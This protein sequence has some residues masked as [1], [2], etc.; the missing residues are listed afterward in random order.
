[1]IGEVLGP[2]RV[3]SKVGEGGMGE[4]YRARDTKLNRDVAIKVLPPALSEDP[5]PSTGSGSPRATS[6]GERVSRLRR[7]AQILATLNHPNIAAI[8]GLEEGAPS[9]GPGQAATIALA[10]EY[11]EGETLEERLRRGAIP[12]DEATAIA[13]QIAEALEAAHEKGI[14]HRDLKP[15]NVKLTPDGKVKVLDFG[16]AKALEGE[17]ADGAGGQL[18]HSPTMS[19]HATEAGLILGTAAY[20]SPEQARGKPVDKRADIWA[21]GVVLF[22][23]LSGARLFTGDTVSDILAAVLTRE[24]DWTALPAAT[25]PALVRLLRRCLERDPKKRLHDIADARFDLDDA[26]LTGGEGPGRQAATGPGPGSRRP[27]FL[28]AGALA[29]TLLGLLAG[30]VA[31]RRLNPPASPGAFRLATV[32]PLGDDFVQQASG[33]AISPDGSTVVFRHT[34]DGHR[35]LFLRSLAELEP[36]FIPGSQ[37]GVGPVFSPDGKSLAFFSMPQGPR[38]GGLYRIKI[39][40]G[41]PFHLAETGTS[42]MAGFT[43][44]GHWTA[45]GQIYFSGSSPVIQRISAA[46]GPV[47]AVTVLDEARGEQRHGQPRVLPGGKG[48]LY[49]AV[50]GGARQDVMVTSSDGAVGRVLVKGAT[51]PRFS[52]TGHLLFALESTIFAAPFDLDALELTGEPFPVA[53]GLE[54][55]VYGNYRHAKFDLAANGTLAY[56][57]ASG[58]R[59]TGQLVLVDRQ[60]RA[61]PAF[62]E[63]GTYLVPRFSPDGGRVAYA[64]IDQEAGERDVWIG[65]LQRGTRTRLTLGKGANTDPIWSP[66]GR[67]I[68]FAS[69]REGGLINLFSV[70]A[71]G[72]GEAVRLTRTADDERAV[73]PRRW[74]RDGNAL[75][76]HVIRASGDIGLWRKD[77]GAEE[78]LLANPFD[79]LQPSLSPDERFL[80]YASDESGRREVY[81]RAMGGSGRRLQVSSEGGDEPVWSPRGDE[82]FY[83]RG[84]QMISVPVSTRGDLTVG[85]TSV[86]FDVPFD[87]DPFNNDATNYDVSRDGQRFIM[88]RRA[89]E[90]GRARQQ[91]NLVVNW[92][93][94]LKRLAREK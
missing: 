62:E 79:E 71:D 48:V 53:E 84:S 66:D 39:E 59:R 38:G 11:V 78:R 74:L 77:S 60:G 94:S 10:M 93:E 26:V 28:V 40:G 37:E 45:E 92:T 20:M 86:L 72:S 64:A 9:A 87:V 88:V 55:A 73:F 50:V 75:V 82:I 85:A 63:P 32:L 54:V 7:E 69:T 33:F 14:V 8:Y 83:R 17:M 29:L 58:S 52:P 46:G 4:V 3:L 67:L 22:E 24:P 35:G 89:I 25:P 18:S 90:P 1:M 68:T 42:A 30:A 47:T 57:L 23:M 34:Q 2:Y 27:A 44:A 31:E 49:V 43:F 81:I 12:E 80:A 16:L 61:T 56:A 91:L 15:A 76:F 5:D 13:K 65:D 36:T 41:A 19:R 21:F 51:T 70:P 6:R